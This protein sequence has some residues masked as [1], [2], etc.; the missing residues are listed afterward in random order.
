M[1]LFASAAEMRP[2]PRSEGFRNGG[3]SYWYREEG[4]PER[5]ASLQGDAEYDVCVVGAGFTGLWTAYYLAEADPGLRVAVV[6]REF[7]GHGAAGRGAGLVTAHFPGPREELARRRGKGAVIALQRAL[8]AAVDEVVSVAEKEDLDAGAVKGG[9]RTSAVNPAQKERLTA[10]VAWLQEWGYWPEDLYIDGDGRAYTPHAADLDPARLAGGLAEAAERGGVEVFEGTPVT[11][12]VPGGSDGPAAVTPFGRVRARTLILATEGFPPPGAEVWPTESCAM[13]ATEPLDEALWEEIGWDGR[14]V[15]ADAAHRP[16][17]ARRTPD[18]RIAV[19][20]RGAL[21]HGAARGEAGTAPPQAIAELWR[22][23]AGMFPEAADVPIAH[24]WTGSVGAPADHA[25]VLTLDRETGVAVA[26]GYGRFGMAL[27]NVVGRTLRDTVLERRTELVRLPWS[28][29]EEARSPR[30]KRI[31]RQ[32]ARGLY[33][34]A[35]KRETSRLSGTSRLATMAE[36]LSP[37]GT[38]E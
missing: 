25:P 17:F 19:G 15:R 1:K 37:K 36:R 2:V 34:G 30:L 28:G 7:A 12:V 6:E 29:L 14:E 38:A 22:A 31:G 20:G 8:M 11:A 10:E 18:G 35:D 3:V 21:P 13:I 9:M 26:G 33:R 24:A 32:V 16:A 27:A 5:R 23:L 4:T